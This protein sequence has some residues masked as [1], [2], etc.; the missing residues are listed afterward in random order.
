MTIVGGRDNKTPAGKSKKQKTK[1]HLKWNA[2]MFNDRF[3]ATQ[4]AVRGRT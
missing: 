4:P 2:M 1:Q 3:K